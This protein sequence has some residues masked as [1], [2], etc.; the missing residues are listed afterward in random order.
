MN[1]YHAALL[2]TMSHHH[3]PLEF[4]GALIAVPL[5]ANDICYCPGCLLRHSSVMKV[6]SDHR[7]DCFY[8]HLVLLLTPWS[9]P[10][11]SPFP[12]NTPFPFTSSLHM[13]F[14]FLLLL[15][16]FCLVAS[17]P[18]TNSLC[19]IA[20]PIAPRW[21]TFTKFTHQATSRHPP[22]YSACSWGK[23]EDPIVVI[24][25]VD[26]I[27]SLLHPHESVSSFDLSLSR[28]IDIPHRTN[29]LPFLRLFNTMAMIPKLARGRRND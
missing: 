26:I 25:H 27:A 2:A 15:L 22:S 28:L 21:R 14:V 3:H 8:H 6:R 11:V 9:L 23:H 10:I 24:L 13:V 17:L 18:H 1:T 7:E 19:A 16:L 12:Y 5:Y 20:M 4:W 29:A